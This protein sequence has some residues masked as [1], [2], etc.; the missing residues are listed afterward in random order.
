MILDKCA[1][2]GRCGDK[3]SFGNVIGGAIRGDL[4]IGGRGSDGNRLE[5]L[6][7]ENLI[8]NS[9]VSAMRIFRLPP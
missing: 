9:Q 3:M 6:C 5:E 2:G 1:Y 7:L 8:V 4:S